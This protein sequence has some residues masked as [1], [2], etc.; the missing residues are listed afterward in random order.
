MALRPLPT[1]GAPNPE[2]RRRLNTGVG[3]QDWKPERARTFANYRCRRSSWN[4]GQ[5][6]CGEGIGWTTNEMCG[7]FAK[8]QHRRGRITR[9]EGKTGRS[10][11]HE[12]LQVTIPLIVTCR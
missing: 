11:A 8:G 3:A 9:S 10:R 12:I 1:C 5:L 4:S 6:V 2:G 7:A